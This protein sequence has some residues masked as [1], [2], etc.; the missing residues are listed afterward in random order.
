MKIKSFIAFV[1][2]ISLTAFAAFAYFTNQATSSNNT[3]STGSILIGTPA[4]GD[5]TAVVS[6]TGILPGGHVTGNVTINNLGTSPFKYKISAANTT[7]AGAALFDA[8][9]VAISRGGTTLYNGPISGLADIVMSTN[10]AVGANETLIFN[11]SL[12]TSIDNTLQN[13]GTNIQFTFDATQID[14]PDWNQ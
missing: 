7:P 4:A 6:M 8:L 11:V 3:I 1:I 9:N 5:N 12:P 14:N 13:L 2:A 10:L